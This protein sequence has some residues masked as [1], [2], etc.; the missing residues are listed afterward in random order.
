LKCLTKEEERQKRKS[1]IFQFLPFSNNNDQEDKMSVDNIAE[2]T[3]RGKPFIGEI[4][5]Y[6]DPKD[7]AFGDTIERR[8]GLCLMRESVEGVPGDDCYI[9][10]ESA[11]KYFGINP[12]EKL[13][14]ILDGKQVGN[15][16]PYFTDFRAE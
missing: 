6:T 4:V 12:E 3:L 7:G 13:P 10:D 8:C 16:C 11:H 14:K 2:N 15:Y 1:Y 5:K 9:V